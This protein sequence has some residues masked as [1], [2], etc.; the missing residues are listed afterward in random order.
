MYWKKKL[1][2][3]MSNIIHYQVNVYYIV[4]TT[5]KIIE[6]ILINIFNSIFISIFISIFNIFKYI[7]LFLI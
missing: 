7:K 6:N 5:S 2:F 4:D 1:K 3:I